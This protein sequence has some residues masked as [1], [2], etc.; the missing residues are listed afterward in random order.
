MSW[1]DR[2]APARMSRVALMMPADS[3]RRTMSAV[4]QAGTVELDPIA[5]GTDSPSAAVSDLDDVVAG[6]ITQ[7]TVAGYVGWMPEAEMPSLAS[8]LASFGAAVVPLHRPAGVEPP[9]LIASTRGRRGAARMLVD[10]YGTVPYA[11]VDPAWLAAT[12][13]VVMF[14]MMFGDAGHGAILLI[15]GILLTSGHP[16]S[17]AGIRRMGGFVVAA[18]AVA[19]V[20]GALYGEF[21]GPTGV[22]PVLWI[23]PLQQ[24]LVL[25]VAGMVLGSTLLAVAYIVGIIDRV[26]E[27]GWGYA[28]YARSGVAGALLFVATALLVLGLV[29]NDVAIVW[30][31]AAVAFVALI[32]IAIGL[33]AQAGGSWTGLL[34]SGVELVNAVVQLGSN[35]VSFARLAAFGLTHAALLAVVWSATT[36]LWAPDWRAIPAILVFVIGNTTTFALEA[37]IA[38]VQA[39]RLEYYELFSR[40]FLTEGRPFRPWRPAIP[41]EPAS[42]PPA[43]I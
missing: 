24:P 32:L 20:F 25:L 13:Y 19:I 14:G 29:V 36:A 5:A 7:D 22:L 6:A 1:R 4:A 28:L 10:T 39:L 16:K 37:L 40:I 12:A 31:A 17:L 2:L 8:V 11:D 15:L 33:V 30:S 9:T 35:I 27:G 41:A 18:G 38:G 3:I 23:A 34:E 42:Q 21:F 26:R 43:G